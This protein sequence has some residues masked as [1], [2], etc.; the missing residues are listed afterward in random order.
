MAKAPASPG[1]RPS[2][3]ACSM[4]ASS[5][6]PLLLLCLLL[7][8][9]RPLV[10]LPASSFEQQLAYRTANGIMFLD[11]LTAYTYHGGPLRGF[12]AQTR[13]QVLSRVVRGCDQEGM[14]HSEAQALA[15]ATAPEHGFD[16]KRMSSGERVVCRGAQLMWNLGNDRWEV[17][18]SSV[19]L[20][21]AGLREA[22]FDVLLLAVYSPLGVHVYRHEERLEDRCAPSVRTA[23]GQDTLQ[24]VAPRGETRWRDAFMAVHGKMQACCTRVLEIP[25][26]DPR[27]ARA[28]ANT[29][30]PPTSAAFADLP[31]AECTSAQRS[32]LVTSL[33]R[34]VD[35]Q[36]LHPD[37]S[38]DDPI[39]LPTVSRRAPK[40]EYEW[41]RDGRRV[42]CK[43]TQLLWDATCMYWK[44]Q[45]SNVKL[46][47]ADVR[48]AAFDEL[49]LA[50]YAPNGIHVLR[51]DMSAGVSTNGKTTA[52][53]GHRI[54]F[55]GRRGEAEW[56]VAL[57]AI[58]SKME[59]GGCTHLARV[60][61][62]GGAEQKT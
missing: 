30:R 42:A 46:P 2:C 31:L 44:V 55:Y 35:A 5:L 1:L 28:V 15:E 9:S 3:L 38:F 19:E 22:A 26:D 8:P 14:L 57:S 45:F 7:K 25:Y 47:L 50:I 49:L 33:V 37:A 54:R 53:G 11:R 51:H 40:P 36:W 58:L 56:R 52:A 23:K 21:V 61:F 29:P 20:P 43:T 32:K 18:F 34:R 60:E 27:I 39:V 12:D 59:D 62:E 41:Q 10:V 16:W 48:E 17:T 4:S 6:L 24:F 13:S